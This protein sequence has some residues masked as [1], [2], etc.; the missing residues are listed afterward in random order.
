MRHFGIGPCAGLMVALNIPAETALAAVRPTA[1]MPTP[2]TSEAEAKQ[3]SERIWNAIG[4][5]E[6]LGVMRTTNPL[7]QAHASG[8]L[9]QLEARARQEEQ[10]QEE[11]E[12]TEVQ[13]ELDAWQRRRA[14]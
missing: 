2:F 1:P 13:R 10:E 5:L 4:R 6:A 9:D 14:A 7:E 8:Y 11:Q 12:D 3:E